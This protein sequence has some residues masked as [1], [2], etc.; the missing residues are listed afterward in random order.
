MIAER[1]PGLKA[2]S[3]AEKRLLMN[4]LWEEVR[5]SDLD[6]PDPAIV[7]LLQERLEHFRANPDS[8]ITL[9]EFRKRLGKS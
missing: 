7:E 1:I 4:E 9:E 6:T 3:I 2:L 8:A 5:N